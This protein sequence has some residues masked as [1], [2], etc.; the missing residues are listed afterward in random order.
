VE[1]DTMR[2]AELLNALA[3]AAPGIEIRMCPKHMVT[4]RVHYDPKVVGTGRT[5]MEAAIDCAHWIFDVLGD[6]P[7]Y[8]QKI[9]AVLAALRA[10][11]DHSMALQV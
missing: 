3:Q 2:E 4:V 9:P 8:E 5:L 11:D 1:N 10:Y 7:E 6:H